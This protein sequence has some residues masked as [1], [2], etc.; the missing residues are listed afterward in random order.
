[1][2][3]AIHATSPTKEDDNNNTTTASS[4]TATH[5]SKLVDLMLP[6]SKATHVLASGGS[7]TEE[8]LLKKQRS[9]RLMKSRSEYAALLE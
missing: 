9:S 7:E 5:H 4:T 8:S 3:K 1:L 6:L 2:T